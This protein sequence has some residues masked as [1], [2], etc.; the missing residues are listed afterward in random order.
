MRAFNFGVPVPLAGINIFDSSDSLSAIPW[1]NLPSLNFIVSPFG[2][3]RNETTG[4]SVNLNQLVFSYNPSRLGIYLS[5]FLSTN[6]NDLLAFSFISSPVIIEIEVPFAQFN[7]GF[8]AGEVGN[9]Q[10]NMEIVPEPSSLSLL[11]A[12]GAVLIA[13]RRKCGGRL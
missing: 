12:G 10:F 3:I 5:E 8:Y 1:H 13:G 4:I 7:Y 2:T 6:G 9:Q 11:L